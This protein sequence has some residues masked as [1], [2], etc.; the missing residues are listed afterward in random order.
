LDLNPRIEYST[1]LGE[2][3]K[4]KSSDLILSK[5]IWGDY[6][7]RK[8]FIMPWSVNWTID[9]SFMIEKSDSFELIRLMRSW[10]EGA[11]KPPI[12]Y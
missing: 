9:M 2:C 5:L 1:L 4:V 8:P 6:S 10:L 11:T 3:D 12:C 7:L